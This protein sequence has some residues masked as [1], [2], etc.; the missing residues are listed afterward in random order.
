M[1]SQEEILDMLVDSINWRDNSDNKITQVL[2]IIARLLVVIEAHNDLST[3]MLTHII[4]NSPNPNKME[5]S[6]DD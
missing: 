1:S 4:Y 3:A 6:N 5:S 2:E